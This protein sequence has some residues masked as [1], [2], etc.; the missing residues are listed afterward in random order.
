[1]DNISGMAMA[2]IG[3]T[4]TQIT[5]SNYHGIGVNPSNSND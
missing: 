4:K 1:V 3:T 5:T 2:P